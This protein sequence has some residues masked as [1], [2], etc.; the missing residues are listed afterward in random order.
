[1]NRNIL[2]RWKKVSFVQHVERD[3]VL[4]LYCA[5]IAL[6][7]WIFLK[8]SGRYESNIEVKLNY[9]IPEGKCLVYNPPTKVNVT[10]AAKGWDLLFLNVFK[11][12]SITINVNNRSSNIVNAV[13]L[14]S[15]ISDVIGSDKSVKSVYF[16]QEYIDLELDDLSRKYIPVAEALTIQTQKGY[17]LVNDSIILSPDSIWI[18]GPKLVIDNLDYWSIEQKSFT[19]LDQNIEESIPLLQSEEY[20]LSFS[21]RN[22]TV[23][24]PIEQVI[25]KQ[26]YVP[27]QALNSADSLMFYPKRVLL[28]C[29]V[30]FD[31]FDQLSADDFM[32]VADIDTSATDKPIALIRLSGQSLYARSV[33]FTPPYVEYKIYSSSED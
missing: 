23:E 19:G 22:I 27:V 12:S 3:R 32:V 30:P 33:R 8:L 14:Q 24:I 15:R 25:E 10:L 28:T 7:F 26:L 4:F 5:G 13:E 16:E 17:D 29:I 20:N 6:F 11:S 1:M 2:N 9:S 18:S 31:Q 21:A